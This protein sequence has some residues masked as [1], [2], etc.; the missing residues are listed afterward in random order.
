MKTIRLILQDILFPKT[1]NPS[2]TLPPTLLGHLGI[3]YLHIVRIG[4][5]KGTAN[6][7]L[8]WTALC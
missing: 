7:H 5:I 1:N 6:A 8:H 2:I 4:F 3:D